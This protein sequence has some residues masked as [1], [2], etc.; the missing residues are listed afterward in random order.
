MHAL[1]VATAGRGRNCQSVS[2][3]SNRKGAAP[4]FTRCGRA[5]CTN[6][7]FVASEGAHARLHELSSVRVGLACVQGVYA[8]GICGNVCQTR[9]TSGDT[10]IAKNAFLGH[11]LSL[12]TAS[13]V[14]RSWRDSQGLAEG[15]QR[16]LAGCLATRSDLVQTT[17]A[18]T[19]TCSAAVKPRRVR[20]RLF[21]GLSACSC[22]TLF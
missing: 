17:S 19:C 15:G 5:R 1:I 2:Q 16:S 18:A 11:V 12:H 7:V 3:S 22:A 4:I 14:A 6:D 8:R 21:A 13:I 10:W 20:A 9:C